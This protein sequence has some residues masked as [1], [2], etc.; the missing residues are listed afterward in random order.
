MLMLLCVHMTRV[1]FLVLVGNSALTMGFYWSYTLYRSYAL[2]TEVKQPK[3]KAP[4]TSQNVAPAICSTE[5]LE[6]QLTKSGKKFTITIPPLLGCWGL[7]RIHQSIHRGC[8]SLWPTILLRTTS[9]TFRV[10]LHSANADEWLKMT[11]GDWKT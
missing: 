5:A 10:L 1:L 7:R 11:D 6:V 3:T 2:L 8:I 9:G 4:S